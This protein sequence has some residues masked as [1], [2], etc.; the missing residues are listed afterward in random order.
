MDGPRPGR[1]DYHDRG[2]LPG[3]FGFG[4]VE[5]YPPD[6]SL[7]GQFLNYANRLRS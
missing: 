6:L 5:P 3:G 4:D 7:R 2:A 1:R